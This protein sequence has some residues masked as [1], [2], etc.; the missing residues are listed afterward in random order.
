MLVLSAKTNLCCTAGC[1][2]TGSF[3]DRPRIGNDVSAVLRKFLPDIGW[4]F[5]VAGAEFGKFW[6]RGKNIG[7]VLCSTLI[8]FR[9]ID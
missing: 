6:C 5:C 8:V 4:L 3:S 7:V 2:R 9:I 1:G